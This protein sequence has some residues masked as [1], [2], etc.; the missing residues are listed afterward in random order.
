MAKDPGNE[1]M[2]RAIAERFFHALANGDFN[3]YWECLSAERRRQ[4]GREWLRERFAKFAQLQV[5]NWQ[6]DEVMPRTAETAWVKYSIIYQ[7]GARA[8]EDEIELIREGQEWRVERSD[9]S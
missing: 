1:E 4:R 9:F 3:S 2:M 7:A 5:R 6:I 8:G